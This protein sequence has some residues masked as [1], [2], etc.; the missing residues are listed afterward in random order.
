MT[1]TRWSYDYE[2]GATPPY[3]H[4]YS[5]DRDQVIAL[6]AACAPEDITSVV[7]LLNFLEDEA[8]SRER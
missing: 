3:W 6:D 1:L 7:E 8:E 5:F 2:E 4:I